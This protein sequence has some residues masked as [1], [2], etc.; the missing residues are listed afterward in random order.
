[1]RKGRGTDAQ[2]C[3]AGHVLMEHRHGLCVDLQISAATGTAEREMAWPILPRHARRGMLPRTLGADHGAPPRAFIRALR[4]RRIRPYVAA[5]VGRQTPG[6]DGRT[7]RS[8]GYVLSQRLRKRVQEI[9][10]WMNTIGGLPKT[11]F[12][13]VAQTKHAADLIGAAYT[14]LRISRLQAQACDR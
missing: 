11:R 13:G 4:H 5:V 12:R 1:M 10:G 2:Q 6:L 7:T 3:F 9:I 8:P 14:L